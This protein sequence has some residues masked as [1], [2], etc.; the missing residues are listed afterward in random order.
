M[1]KRIMRANPLPVLI[2]LALGLIA[3]GVLLMVQKEEDARRPQMAQNT[4]R[5]IPTQ[6][7]N[8]Q[9]ADERGMLDGLLDAGRRLLEGSGEGQEAEPAGEE[10]S[11]R[12][13]DRR[14]QD[15][16]RLSPEEEQEIGAE[17]H[18]VIGEEYPLA[19]DS[20]AGERI[21]RLARPLLE[22]HGLDAGDFRFS[23]IDSETVNAFAHVG[24]YV[25][26]NR[27]LLDLAENDDEVQFV[28]SHEIAHIVLGHCSERLTYT[29]RS[30]QVL[31]EDAGEIIGL[32]YSLIAAGYFPEQ[33][34]EADEF[35]QETML[36]LGKDP[37]AG[38]KMLQRIYE[39]FETDEDVELPPEITE[40]RW[41]RILVAVDQH[42]QTHPDVDERVRRIERVQQ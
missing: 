17:F 40:S 35:A 22:H 15:L 37:R 2:A 24:G 41:Y 4:E 11:L 29:V 5:G 19:P 23:L 16:L 9:P 6:R 34:F 10:F 8:E 7:L 30:Q 28:L 42:L 39:G 36:A 33:E 21:A 26:V 27:G 25:Y 12:T 14:A 18:R 20:P 1:G 38:V 32:L 13:L 31:G 3:A